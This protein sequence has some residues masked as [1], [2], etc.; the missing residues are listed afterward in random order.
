M[1]K[2]LI[3]SAALLLSATAAMAQSGTFTLKANLKNFG[4]TVIVFKNRGVKNDTILVKK[5][6]FTYTT[7][8][9]K[10]MS[11]ISQLQVHSATQSTRWLAS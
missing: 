4:D 10:P 2:N 5:D 11:I 3:L 1:K 8:L 6:K 9:D 7:T